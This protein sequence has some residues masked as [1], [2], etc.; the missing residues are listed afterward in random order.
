MSKTGGE[1]HVDPGRKT[2]T[3]T[4]GAPDEGGQRSAQASTDRG[5]QVHHGERDEEDDDKDEEEGVQEGERER[6]SERERAPRVPY[7]VTSTVRRGGASMPSVS[8]FLCWEETPARTRW[9]LRRMWRRCVR[10]ILW[11]PDS[12]ELSSNFPC[13]DELD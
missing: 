9:N 13:C 2:G 3:A 11:D 10:E 6:E 7:S 12:A 4:A 1:C 5:I 8:A